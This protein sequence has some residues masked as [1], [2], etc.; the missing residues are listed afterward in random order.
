MDTLIVPRAFFLRV[1]SRSPAAG[2][3]GVLPLGRYRTD[4][5]IAWLGG[6]PTAA[7]GVGY[8]PA[9]AV[10]RTRTPPNGMT[11]LPAPPAGILLVGDGALRGHAWAVVRAGDGITTPGV[12]ALPGAGMHRLALDR[13][14]GLPGAMTLDAQAEVPSLPPDLLAVT[15][16]DG[17]WSRTIG[18]PGGLDVWRRP[19]SL[20]VA[21]VGVGR[22]G[23]LVAASLVRLGV[24]DLTLID[25][26][27]LED[28]SLPEMDVVTAA[29]L[30]QP[31]AE[32]VAAGLRRPV[33][34]TGGAPDG[35]G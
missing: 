17:R 18:A 29:D 21:V 24:A 15:G 10:R 30:G 26:D 14:P 8:G 16:G 34:G 22:T 28:H 11:D 27:I 19:V 23:S 20:R 12:L 7:T 3:G 5:G 1:L 13:W 25:A 33:S 31:K 35:P 2:D 6:A 4:A 32:A 9:L